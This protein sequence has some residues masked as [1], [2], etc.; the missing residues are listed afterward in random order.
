MRQQAA[1]QRRVWRS[2]MHRPPYRIPPA[3][4]EA[5]RDL[6]EWLGI[7]EG[8]RAWHSGYGRRFPTAKGRPSR[9]A[10][11]GAARARWLLGARRRG[12]PRAVTRRSPRNRREVRQ[13]EMEPP[14]SRV[15]YFQ[16]SRSH[17][18]NSRSC[19]EGWR[20]H[21]QSS[22]S[23]LESSRSYLESSRS[24]L[25]GVSRIQTV[26]LDKTGTLTEGKPN[27]T[28]VI[29]A[30]GVTVNEVLQSAAGLSSQSTHPC[31]SPS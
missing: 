16:S 25:E 30:E 27:V 17:V 7:A 26:I 28:D 13:G 3:R 6:V 4:D 20:S 14:R 10:S 8:S 21:L 31:R 9:R 18:Q 19:L 23:H 29:P 11:G 24:H 5:T 1:F 2:G 12:T 15:G 22:R